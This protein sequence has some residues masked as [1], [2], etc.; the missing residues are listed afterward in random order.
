VCK[1]V[2]AVNRTYLFV[3]YDVPAVYSR[4]LEVSVLNSVLLVEYRNVL[5][6]SMCVVFQYFA[7][8]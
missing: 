6:L 5:I 1:T 2:C 8:Y 4:E 3:C 7:R